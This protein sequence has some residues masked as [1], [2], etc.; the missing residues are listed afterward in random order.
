LRAAAAAFALLLAGLAA[1]PS[2]ASPRGAQAR[3]LWLGP[4]PACAGTVAQA[5]V[6]SDETF[7]DQSTAIITFRPAWR[8]ALRRETTRLY[9]RPMQVWL[10]GRLVS[11]PIVREPITGGMVALSGPTARQAERIRAAALRPCA[12]GIR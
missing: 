9:N 1:A 5:A 2:V 10:D 4:I 12:R 8:A 7:P 6:A 11:S 3:G